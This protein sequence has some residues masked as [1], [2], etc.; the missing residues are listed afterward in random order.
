MK[1]STL[2]RALTGEE[3]E[4]FQENATYKDINWRQEG[5]KL[6]LGPEKR[7]LFLK[8]L[9]KDCKLLEKLN[10]MDYSLLVGIHRCHTNEGSDCTRAC[11]EANKE[12]RRARKEKEQESKSKKRKEK[13]SKK[14][15]KEKQKEEKGEEKG[16]EKVENGKEEEE[17]NGKEEEEAIVSNGKE[18]T[19]ATDGKEEEPN[20]TDGKE[21]E[22]EPPKTNGES[23]EG[24]P[25][26]I[27]SGSNS[28][29]RV[30]TSPLR[31]FQSHEAKEPP[32]PSSRVQT[33]FPLPSKFKKEP[34][35]FKVDDGGMRAMDEFGQPLDEYYFVGIIDI[36][37]LYSLRKRAER[38]YKMVRFGGDGKDISSINPVDYSRRFQEFL[39]ENTV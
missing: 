38:T 37:M 19:K 4:M 11:Y 2:G 6:R 16:E 15:G 8:Q 10:I 34:S 18:E 14:S 39:E 29:R 36:L 32:T 26:S 31:R 23:K 20:P 3:Q 5:R 17:T 35:I 28:L 22:P 21:E 33:S 9:E 1:G 7:E 24:Q 25:K 27:K 30:V 13:K 12:V